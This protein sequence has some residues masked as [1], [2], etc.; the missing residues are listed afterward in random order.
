LG[1]SVTLSSDAL[2]GSGLRRGFANTEHLPSYTQFNAAVEKA[3]DFGPGFGK[4]SGRLAVINVFD[5]VYEL[6]DGS[7]IGVGAPQF[8]PRRTFVAGVTKSF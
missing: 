6:R 2:Y 8:G 7:G 3:F 1:E 5:R 4:I